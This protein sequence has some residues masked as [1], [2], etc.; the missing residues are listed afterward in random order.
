VNDNSAGL[1]HSASNYL[2]T[3][4]TDL[5]GKERWVSGLAEGFSDMFQDPLPSGLLPERDEG[6]LISTKP[7]HPPPFRPMYR[8]SPLEYS[9]LQ[10]QDSAFLK[11]GILEPFKS[12]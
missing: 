6:H 12:P 9:E 7:G 5:S 1:P 10:K 11:A 4:I 3:D 2:A 8:L